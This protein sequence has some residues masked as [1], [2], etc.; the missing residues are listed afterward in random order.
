STVAVVSVYRCRNAAFVQG[1]LRQLPVDA[2]VRLWS[3]DEIVPDLATVTLGSGP[4]SRFALLN[5]L[6]GDLPAEPD[7][8]VVVDDDVRF[9]VGDLA[10]LVHAGSSL[11]LDLFQP[12]HS[13]RSIP[14]Y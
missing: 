8:L 4:G 10:R 11:G 9:V 6:I 7:M 12:A 13:R 14:A 2:V 3:L 1:L 5:M